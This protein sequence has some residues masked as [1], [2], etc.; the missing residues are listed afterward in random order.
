MIAFSITGKGVP[1]SPKT[2]KVDILDP[3]DAASMFGGGGGVKD[4]FSALLSDEDER[5]E[6]EVLQ[7]VRRQLGKSE[8]SAA[9]RTME[10]S[11]VNGSQGNPVGKPVISKEEADDMLNRL[12][13]LTDEE[14]ERVFAKMRQ[15]IASAA[16]ERLGASIEERRSSMKPPPR[17]APQ[18]PEVR[19][20]YEKELS[21]IE[22]ELESIYRDPLKVWEEI[23]LNPD[24]YLG[25]ED[26]KGIEDEELQ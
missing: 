1:A 3:E 17:A 14:V 9:P 2:K 16:K 5:E 11:Q 12:D 21:A 4:M 26:P 22:S 19:R 23:M 10:R 13:N 24:K 25:K 6:Q 20:R 18:D 15:S 7:K 8:A